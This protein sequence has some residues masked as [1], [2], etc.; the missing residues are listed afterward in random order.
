VNFATL[1]IKDHHNNLRLG[2]AA[3]PM[4]DADRSQNKRAAPEKTKGGENMNV[5]MGDLILVVVQSI[6][7]ASVAGWVFYCLL[8]WVA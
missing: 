6:A 7:I 8:T 2:C 4:R 5:T 1:Q 3:L